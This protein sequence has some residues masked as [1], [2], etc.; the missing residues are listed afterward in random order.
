MSR[1]LD[2]DS[3]VLLTS[4][5][6]SRANLLRARSIHDVERVASANTW[7]A[8]TI[9]ETTSL[10]SRSRITGDARAVNEDGIARVVGPHR[11]VN[12]TR[13][14]GVESVIE[15]RRKNI[16]TECLV[17]IVKAALWIADARWRHGSNESSME[18]S[19]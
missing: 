15:P 9:T 10:C 17:K 5:F 1:V 8:A 4:P 18:R 7:A 19:I 11:V 14:I 3:H 12:A 13:I 2:Y 16:L 6:Q